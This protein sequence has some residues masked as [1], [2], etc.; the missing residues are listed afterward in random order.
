M[1]RNLHKGVLPLIFVALI[2][3]TAL[4]SAQQPF[5]KNG[6]DGRVS[7]FLRKAMEARDAGDLDRAKTFWLQAKS[8]R[9]SIGRPAWL[10][11]S[12]SKETKQKL[13]VDPKTEVLTMDYQDAKTILEQQLNASPGDM[14][15]RKIYLELAKKNNDF[16]QV[17]RHSMYLDK[18]E[19][20]TQFWKGILALV[21]V[22]IGA[23]QILAFIKDWKSKS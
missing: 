9:P 14:E 10:D 13:D 7:F 19:S 8:V 11:S 1:Y 20:Q 16:S 15:T 23:W 2:F 22:L 12:P 21:L 17:N 5:I 3:F 6:V 18:V 4:T